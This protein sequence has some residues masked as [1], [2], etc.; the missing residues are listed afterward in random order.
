MNAELKP[1]KQGRLRALR[2]ALAAGT[3]RSAHRMINALHPAEIALLIESLPPAQRE[4]VWEFVDHELEGEVLVELNENVRSALMEG[5]D[6]DELLAAAEDMEL[7]D[8]AD[9]VGDLPETVTQ[10]LL[11]SMD[12]Q[13]RKRLRTED[14][15]RA[16]SELVDS[17]APR[18]DP[19]MP[20]H[21]VT[22]LFQDRDLVSAAVVNSDG[23]LLGRI[24]I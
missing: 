10:R 15:E 22:Q 24:T 13:D 2:T 20:A 16:I 19:L 3:L 17:E 14:P 6:A 12:L 21:E 23:R 1:E 4:V 7:D 5:M 8:L 11:K 18:I 9:L